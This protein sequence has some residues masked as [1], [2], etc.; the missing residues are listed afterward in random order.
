MPSTTPV[1]LWPSHRLKKPFKFFAIWS[2]KTA[3]SR[4]LEQFTKSVKMFN[5]MVNNN[6]DGAQ[7]IHSDYKAN[8]CHWP[9]PACAA[10]EGDNI[11]QP[12]EMPHQIHEAMRHNA[13]IDLLIQI[14]PDP[15]PLHVRGLIDFWHLPLSSR[16]CIC[17]S[18][19]I[20]WP[21]MISLAPC[22]LWCK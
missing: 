20:E 11:W 13:E 3:V 17:S 10:K 6:H 18:L 19:S 8:Q 1:N 9:S 7:G 14:C 2:L 21:E 22:C 4:E 15:F 5:G 16:E 12:R